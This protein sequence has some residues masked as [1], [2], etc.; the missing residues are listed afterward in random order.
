MSLTPRRTLTKIRTAG[1]FY[2]VV[3]EHD[4]AQGQTLSGTPTVRI[5]D[6]ETGTDMSADFPTMAPDYAL[7]TVDGEDKRC[8]RFWLGKAEATAQPP[9][10]YA[11]EALFETAE[12]RKPAG[13]DT[14][15]RLPMLIVRNL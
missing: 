1:D 12:G 14:E 6:H 4:L 9:G 10:R 2:A 8:I 11:V 5:L 15:G 13:V 7:I 3:L